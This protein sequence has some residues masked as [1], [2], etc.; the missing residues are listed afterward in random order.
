M[1]AP[2]PV[3]AQPDINPEAISAYCEIVFGYLEG[4]APIRLLSESGTPSRSARLLFPSTIAVAGAIFA[5]AERAAAEQRGVFVVPGTVVASGSARAED[6]VATGVLLVDLDKG[7]V[8]AARNH[9]AYHL[10][11]PTLEIASGGVT[12]GGSPKLHLYWRLTEA[13]TGSDLDL[14]CSLRGTIAAKVGGNSSFK[15]IHQPIRVAGTIHGKHGVQNA[16]RLLNRQEI[17]FDLSDLADAV[18]AMPPLPGIEPEIRIDTGSGK[19]PS[20]RDLSKQLVREG[21]Q[22]GVTRFGALSSVIGHWIRNVRRGICTIDEARQAVFD[23]NQA[24]IAPP[25]DERRLM[26]EFSALMQKD[27]DTFGPMPGTVAGTSDDK[28][29]SVEA[30]SFSEDALAAAFTAK[31]GAD[32]R[33]VPAWGQWLRWTGGHWQTDETKRVREEIRQI[34]RAAAVSVEKPDEAKRIASDR[35]LSAVLRIAAS[36]PRIATRTSDWDAYADLLNTPAGIIDLGSGELEPHDPTRLLTQMTKASPGISCRR[37]LSFLTEIT[38][39]DTQLQAY[40]ARL[41]GY[42]LTGS[43]AEQVFAFLHG[44][45][46]NGK[47]V[48]L[49]TI[50]R[51]MG[52]YA[53]TAALDTFMATKSARHLTE[54]AGLR[55]ARLVLVPETEAGQSWAEA[56][57]KQVTGGEKVRANFMHRDHFE[58][59]PQ[60]KLLVAGNHRPALTSVGEAL[61]RRLHLVPFTV[62]IPVDKR[63][64]TLAEKLFA[65]R[66]G[67]LGWMISG[68]AEWRRMGLIPPPAVADA[69]EDYFASEDH[70][71]QWIDECCICGPQHRATSRELY[72]AW[73][74]WSETGGYPAGSTKSLGEMLRAR[75]FTDGKV[76]GARGWH[77]ISL[78]RRSTIV[79]AAG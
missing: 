16:V 52:S 64:P 44:Q 8:E 57:I 21:G 20:V 1:S 3:A 4:L 77:G 74:S 67:I 24:M 11:Q 32:W 63:D 26:R 6:V 73:Q 33:H 47:S 50:V 54:L 10:G 70:V 15:S 71:G 14:V 42:C 78:N 40:L 62:T 17:E 53:A 61:R 72:A 35:T 2:K 51:V 66:D 23:H 58:F 9:L 49:Q 37:W 79:E 38:G 60:F 43:T 22:D 39:G 28:R 19:G 59:Q 36:D 41:A 31:H 65:E 55:A 13:A 68:C 5:E 12:E 56:R 29:A 69:A 7:D 18:D 30:P 48:F 46:A 75:G 25:W 34:C 45:G 27:I 76:K